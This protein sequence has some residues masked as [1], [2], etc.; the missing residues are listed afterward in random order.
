MKSRAIFI[1]STFI[2]L[3]GINKY[4]LHR[5][6]KKQNEDISVINISGKQ[7]M[8]SQRITKLIFYNGKYKNSLAN[9]I[10]SRELKNTIDQFKI[11][12][13]NLK[14]NH[15]AKYDD[16]YLK[17]LFDSLENNYS[18]IVNN[19]DL[20]MNND[21]SQETY[22]DYLKSIKQGSDGFLPIM[23][24]IVNHYELIAKQRGERIISRE[25]TFN[26]ILLILSIYGVFFLIIPLA[27][28]KKDTLA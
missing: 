24:D 20:L 25:L 2:I 4:S 5:D 8:Y 21:N 15:L 7:R 28:S 27:N 13:A 3:L 14:T 16:N 22:D 11:A 1:L 26:I 10:N 12:H 6:I 23:D 9:G 17:Q 18:S 19:V